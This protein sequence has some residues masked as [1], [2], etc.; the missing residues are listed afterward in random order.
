MPWNSAMPVWHEMLSE[1]EV[2]NVITFLYDY[3]AQ[4]PRMWDQ[5]VSKAVTT[6]K[7]Q[8]AAQRAKMSS[9]DLYQLRCAVCHGEKG[10][11]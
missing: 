8:V 10:V 3:V 1:E 2:W 11:V 7:D 4:V 6:M 5:S 9:M